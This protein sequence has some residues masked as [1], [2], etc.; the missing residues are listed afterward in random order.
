M[1]NCWVGLTRRLYPRNAMLNEAFD[2]YACDAL[3]DPLL[4]DAWWDDSYL[5]YGSRMVFDDPLDVETIETPEPEEPLRY[6]N[7]L[8]NESVINQRLNI[9]ADLG[10]H[11]FFDTQ[12]KEETLLDGGR[13]PNSNLDHDSGSTRCSGTSEHDSIGSET[14]FYSTVGT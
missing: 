5:T 12:S 1:G 6:S 7:F 4:G 8:M 2:P 11:E 14:T 9:I 3:T 13:H 10:P